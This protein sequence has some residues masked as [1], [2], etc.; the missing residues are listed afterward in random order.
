[1]FHGELFELLLQVVKSWQVIAITVALVLYMSLVGYAARTYHRPNYVSKSKP[2]K[3]TEKA[4]KKDK[5]K[6]NKEKDSDELQ[7]IEE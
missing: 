5:T 6:S 1:M 2:Q 3:T 4:A 7:I